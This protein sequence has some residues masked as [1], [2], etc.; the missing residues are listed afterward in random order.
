M[1]QILIIFK[2]SFQKY[3][4]LV[5]IAMVIAILALMRIQ[6]D[7]TLSPS[8]DNFKF[9]TKDYS[10]SKDKTTLTVPAEGIDRLD[11]IYARTGRM[12]L[13]QGKY[14][15]E[16]TYDC[17]GE[18]GVELF[19]N[20]MPFARYSLPPQNKKTT[21]ALPFEL[22]N[23]VHNFTATLFNTS[24]HDI[25][26]TEKRLI[27]DRLIYADNL[28]FGAILIISVFIVSFLIRKKIFTYK[29]LIPVFFVLMV[30]YPL[31]R[32]DLLSGQDMEFHLMRIE[33]IKDALLAGQFPPTIYPNAAY[34]H[35]YLGALYPSLFLYIP[36][37]LRIINV[38][39]NM[40]LKTLLFLIN[41]A[42]FFTAY[43]SISS[44]TKNK[45]V[46]TLAAALYCLSP[47]ADL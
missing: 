45:K 2:T 42:S 39:P 15:F 22:E 41:A 46:A 5:L 27:C 7:Y 30:S 10:I 6:S 44:I 3:G 12:Y 11:G 36:A 16:I 24:G 18:S 28:F 21:I 26:I 9:Y 37:F 47:N 17:A 29:S 33:G 38:S 32:P 23:D 25:T 8:Y 40:A 35:G 13:P 1:K 4:T 43:Y 14:Q 34:E 19:I 20:D 31:F